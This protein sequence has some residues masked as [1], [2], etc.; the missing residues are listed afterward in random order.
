MS[1]EAAPRSWWARHKWLMARRTCQALIL[2][3]FLLGPV[4]D[5]WL[6]KGTLAS[7]N[8][9]DILALTDPFIALQSLAAGHPLS[10]VAII[11]ALIVAGF[12]MAF[13][14]RSFC[15][16][17]CPIN[18][19]TDGASW[20][21]RRLNI[22]SGFSLPKATRLWLVPAML[23]LSWALGHIAFEAINPITMLQRGLL[24]GL[25][26]GWLVVLAVFVFDLFAVKHGWCGHLCPVGAFYGLLGRAS[27]VKVSA[28]RRLDCTNCGDCFQVCPEPQVIAPALY[29][30]QPSDTPLILNTDCTS[31]GKCM[32]VCEPDVLRFT[33][34]FDRRVEDAIPPTLRD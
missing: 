6:V 30:V 23:V 10:S 11:G 28:A 34:R 20:L 4:A 3:V 12:Y 15:A 2:G 32:D 9:L 18:P 25:G 24:F 17:V 31:C 27:L 7:S 26:L 14:G 33:H 22:R 5:I 16:W 19:V 21:R 29:P 13:G 8:V 1:H